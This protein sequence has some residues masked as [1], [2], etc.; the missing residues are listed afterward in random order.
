M[1]NARRKQIADVMKQL[2]P[3]I[4]A[5]ADISADI[6]NIKEEEQEYYDNIPDSLKSSERALASENALEY[7]DNAIQAIEEFTEADIVSMLASSSE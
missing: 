7:L 3:L 1:N 2:E 4:A 6:D 5:I